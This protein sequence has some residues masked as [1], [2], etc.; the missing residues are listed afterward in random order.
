[1]DTYNE[2]NPC[3]P[4]NEKESTKTFEEF[5]SELSQEDYNLLDEKLIDLES[6][7]SYYKNKL[8]F[9]KT[10]EKNVK[11]FFSLLDTFLPA[12]L[13]DRDLLIELA[14]KIRN[15]YG[16]MDKLEQEIWKTNYVQPLF[17]KY[18]TVPTN[19]KYALIEKDYIKM[20]GKKEA[21]EQMKYMYDDTEAFIFA[22]DRANCELSD[23]IKV[24]ILRKEFNWNAYKEYAGNEN[25]SNLSE[26]YKDFERNFQKKEFK[27]DWVKLILS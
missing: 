5:T 13:K 21:R 10:K 26:E 18:E 14:Q 20:F 23:R 15:S 27:K 19:I 3:N 2:W 17:D 11:E 1:M 8:E 16:I 12:D 25:K 6:T 9:A 7:I 22:F 24:N 4:I